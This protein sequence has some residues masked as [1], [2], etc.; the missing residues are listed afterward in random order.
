MSGA[1]ERLQS[2]AGSRGKRP[3]TGR[4]GGQGHSPGPMVGAPSPVVRAPSEVCLV[5]RKP[6]P[7]LRDGPL[8]HSPAL[9]EAQAGNVT[10][11]LIPG[12]LVPPEVLRRSSG[13]VASRPVGQIE[14][15]QCRRQPGKLKHGDNR[16]KRL[17]GNWPEWTPETVP[18]SPTGISTQ[19][20]PRF[21]ES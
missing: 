16:F 1:G 3:P 13:W 9:R 15:E 7:H 2:V 5:R 19:R 18:S 6:G 8:Q 11:F 10:K 4:R 17:P 20:D 12:E 21:P 14:E